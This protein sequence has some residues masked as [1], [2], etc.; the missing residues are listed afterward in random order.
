MSTI[1][2]HTRNMQAFLLSV[3]LVSG[4]N[5]L[6]L[7]EVAGIDAGDGNKKGIGPF[8]HA[9]DTVIGW[10]TSFAV[11]AAPAAF[12]VAAILYLMGRR[13]ALSIAACA[14]GAVILVG[15]SKGLV[16]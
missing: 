12:L 3:L 8:L 1:S 16:A 14:F 6:A 4:P 2:N 5:L 15:A 10:L 13:Q 11:A 9:A 7:R